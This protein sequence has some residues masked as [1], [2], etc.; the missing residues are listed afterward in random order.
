MT[1]RLVHT[2]DIHLDAVFAASGLPPKYGNRRRQALRDA[3]RAIVARVAAW[4]ADALL[5]AGDLFEEDRIS[6]DTVAFLQSEFESLFPIPVCIAPGNHDPLTTRSP[7]ATEI[8]PGNVTVFPEPRWTSHRME[9]VPLTVHGFAFD[10]PDISENPFGALQI[11]D[12]GRIHVAVAHGS[13][14]GCLPPEKGAYAPFTAAQAASRGLRYLA[15]GHYHSL[16]IIET[17]PGTRLCYPGAPEGHGFRET[18]PMHYVEVEI[19]TDSIRIVPVVSSRTIYTVDRIECTAF[20][21]TQ[22]VVDAIRAVRNTDGFNQI[23]RVELVGACTGSWREQLASVRD[24]L[25]SQ[26]EALDLIDRLEPEEDYEALAQENTSLGVFVQYVNERIRFTEDPDL[27]RI[28]MRAREVGIAAYRGRDLPL[29][30]ADR[31]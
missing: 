24:A 19:E 7:Y 9:S 17:E 20:S 14:M 31:S 21:T 23:A 13:E 28:L 4:P 1:I 22:Q 11:P 30:G 6:R 5:I 12:D 15:L 26:F 3:F 10:G 8:W 27:R 18:G 2:S 29:R 25:A 16:K